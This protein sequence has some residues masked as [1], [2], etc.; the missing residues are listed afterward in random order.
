MSIITQLRR[1]PLRRG[2][3]VQQVG[4]V[5]ARGQLRGQ[6]L[7]KLLERRL[8]RQRVAV[9]AVQLG[10]EAPRQRQ[11]STQAG[12]G[13]V[14]EPQVRK[15]E[16]RVWRK[17]GVGCVNS[18]TAQVADRCKELTLHWLSDIVTTTL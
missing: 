18:T 15:N 17:L 5:P 6:P 3:G 16:N 8:R 2:E 10:R 9:R 14:G 7:P 4:G 12:K 11:R 1:P 13:Q